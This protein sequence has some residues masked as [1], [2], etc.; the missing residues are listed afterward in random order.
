MTNV[1]LPNDSIDA[2]IFCLSLMGVDYGKAILEA[3]RV[4]KDKGKLFIAEVRSRFANAHAD[5]AVNKVGSHTSNKTLRLFLTA[6]KDAGFAVIP[7]ECDLK[8]NSHF[9]SISCQLNKRKGS[10]RE[11]HFPDLK[12][13][14]YK[15]R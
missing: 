13:C 4:L 9:I 15:K 3:R 14:T 6:L 1:P 8:S 11:H 7:V 12:P 5:Y 2:A 10:G